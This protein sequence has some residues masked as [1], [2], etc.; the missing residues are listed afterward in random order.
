ME[1]PHHLLEDEES[2][3]WRREHAAMSVV[4]MIK[5]MTE[6]IYESTTWILTINN[7]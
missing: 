2:F 1:K 7:E 3:I 5:K 4:M 6:L